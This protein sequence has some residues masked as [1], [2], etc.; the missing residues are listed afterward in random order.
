[1][2]RLL[3]FALA[4]LL[5]LTLLPGLAAVEALDWREARDAEVTRE[6]TIGK[7]WLTPVYA[8]EPFFEKPLLAYAPELVAQRVL[9]RTD[10]TAAAGH[11]TDV[12]TSRAVRAA[13]AAALA[14]L[15]AV[16]GTRAFGVRAGWLAGCALA[17]SV[18]L[19]LAA[20]ADGGQL[21]ATLCAWLGIG[22][23]LEV[24]QGRSRSPDATRFVAWFAFGAAMLV[25]GP[26]GAFWP[27]GGFALYF[28]LA[29]SRSAWADVRPGA[30]TLVVLA[31]ALPWYGVMTMLYRGDF[32][33]RVPFFPYATDPRTNWLAGP[34]VA[35][36]YPMVLGFPWSPL[37][38]A[39]LRDTAE[40]LRRGGAADL[41]ESG[42]A[43]SLLLALLV[44]ACV[45]VAVVPHAPLTA[46]LPALPALAL[47]CGRFLDR[48][49][50]GDVDARLL[51]GAARLAAALG[52]AMALLAVFVATR[53]DEAAPALR[54]LGA[55]LLV[56]SCVPWLADFAGRRKLAAALFALPIALG[57]PIVT[58][59]VLPALEPWLDTRVVAEAV[60]QVAPP[61]AP[62]VLLEPA[63]PSLRLLL[64]RN[65]V[66]VRDLAAADTS[67]A[68]RDGRVYVAFPPEREH[69]AAR[70]ARAPLEILRRSPTLVLARVDAVA[71]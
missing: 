35:L 17:S 2:R 20:R 64:P 33:S 58:T 8:H 63:P 62:L 7:E 25:A 56:T 15:V 41:R 24:L 51:T 49:L 65:F 46:A 32:L 40:R 70:S 11:A 31:M 10:S 13:L 71:P 68:G 27:L 50:D 61:R 1:M 42:H 19:P 18:G 4:A 22:A 67:L 69:D 23:L 30:G 55:T 48:V 26:L 3:P 21:L 14:L 28:A 66:L 36:S 34:L 44:A 43:A 9:A 52:T 54:L 37:L 16:V 60:E 12:A 57:T 47:L 5:G 6:S 39:S 59:R 45:P 29:R 38:A 53:I